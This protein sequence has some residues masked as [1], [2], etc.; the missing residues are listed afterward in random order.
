M[1]KHLIRDLLLQFCLNII[2]CANHRGPGRNSNAETCL[3]ISNSRAIVVQAST[4]SSSN[5]RNSPTSDAEGWLEAAVP[6]VPKY[7]DCP[8]STIFTIP[9]CSESG[10]HPM[11]LCKANKS[12]GAWTKWDTLCPFSPWPSATSARQMTYWRPS[13]FTIDARSDFRMSLLDEANLTSVRFR[14]G[15]GLGAWIYQNKHCWTYLGIPF[16]SWLE[17]MVGMP[18]KTPPYSLQCYVFEL[19]YDCLALPNKETV[20][21][22]WQCTQRDSGAWKLPCVVTFGQHKLPPPDKAQRSR[23]LTPQKSH[24]FVCKTKK[25]SSLSMS[26]SST[27]G[28]IPCLYILTRAFDTSRLSNLSRSEV[29]DLLGVLLYL[30]PSC[31]HKLLAA[32]SELFRASLLAIAVRNDRISWENSSH[33][34]MAQIYNALQQWK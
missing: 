34:R 28:C 15:R 19:C 10:W 23:A 30:L 3:C 5:L 32:C 27:G 16:L 25:S 17:L 22:L 4:R 21:L 6:E 20:E 12:Y 11:M 9:E 2:N 24:S 7:R 31:D 29:L 14:S 18:L 8:H 26:S 1:S 13:F 33:R